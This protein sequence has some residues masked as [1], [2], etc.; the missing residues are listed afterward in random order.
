MR[1]IEPKFELFD[2]EHVV[3]GNWI[4]GDGAG[5]GIARLGEA[6]EAAGEFKNTGNKA[7]MLMKTKGITFLNAANQGFLAC[8]S[9]QIT[10]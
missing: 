7:R 9:V 3:A 2:I 8:Q 1:E 6:R 10:P 4:V 5:S